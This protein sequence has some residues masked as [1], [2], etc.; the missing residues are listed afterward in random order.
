MNR[1]VV[2]LLLVPAA[3]L[4]ACGSGSGSSDSGGAGTAGA[5][6]PDTAVVSLLRAV[7]AGSCDAALKVVVTPDDLDCDQVAS[8][9]GSYSDDG[10]DLDSVTTTVGDVVDGSTTVTVDLG[11]DDPDEQWQAEQVD[12]RWRVLFD[13]EA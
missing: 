3:A 11:T 7:D 2:T 10:V 9:K 8:L 5:A 12:G 4:G 13:S 6:A 1:A